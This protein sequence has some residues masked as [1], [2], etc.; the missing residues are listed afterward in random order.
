MAASSVANLSSCREL[1]RSRD[2]LKKH[3]SEHA[4]H[5]LDF[6]HLLKLEYSTQNQE[7]KM[8]N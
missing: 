2:T 4:Q 6:Y 7:K 1:T 5:Q 8:Q 3:S